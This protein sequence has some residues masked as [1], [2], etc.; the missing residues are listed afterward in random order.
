MPIID[1]HAP[2]SFC[3]MELAAPDQQ[4]AKA[5]YAGLF[6]WTAEDH[7]MGP[8]TFYTMFRLQDRNAAAARTL[9]ADERESGVPPHW[10]LYI[11]T[12]NADETV[13]RTTE[14]GGRVC[15]GPFDVFDAGRMAMLFD[16]S[17]APF[18]IWE[19]K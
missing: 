1:K 16:P 4:L 5:F 14:L 8:S 11:A 18:A 15:A 17:G 9:G 6:G 10:T 2:G 3:W 7:P 19:P 12:D 13:R